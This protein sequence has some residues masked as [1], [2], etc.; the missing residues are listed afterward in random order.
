MSLGREWSDVEG[1]EAFDFHAHLMTSAGGSPP[2]KS[3]HV[4]GA[5]LLVSLVA[6]GLHQDGRRDVA[7]AGLKERGA[8]RAR[9]MVTVL[10]L[11]L[12]EDSS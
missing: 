6:D 12:R 1:G 11:A 10:W 3:E 8:I 9:S 4:D 7:A 5:A 2:A